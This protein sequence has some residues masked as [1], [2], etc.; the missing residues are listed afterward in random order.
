MYRAITTGDFW[1]FA[2]LE[3]EHKRIVRDLNQ[4][5]LP[6]DVNELL[7]ILIGLMRP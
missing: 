7:S 4:Y 3:Q 1:Q 5:V 6:K 2:L